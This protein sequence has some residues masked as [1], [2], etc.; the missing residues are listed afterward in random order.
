MI[1]YV[2]YGV[3]ETGNGTR[4]KELA[5]FTSQEKLKSYI[6]R[7][8][9]PDD[10]RLINMGKSLFITDKNNYKYFVNNIHPMITGLLSGYDGAYF[11]RYGAKIDPIL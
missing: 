6:Y 8:L 10:Q 11:V 7:S 9:D 3:Q 2:L 1:C 4:N 5:L